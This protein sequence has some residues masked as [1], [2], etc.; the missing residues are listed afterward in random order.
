MR[1]GWGLLEVLMVVVVVTSAAAAEGGRNECRRLHCG[2]RRGVGCRGRRRCVSQ[3]GAG[4]MTAAC[5]AGG[6]RLSSG[7]CGHAVGDVWLAQA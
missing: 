2:G 5:M 6:G 7:A 4:A 1:V 3:K